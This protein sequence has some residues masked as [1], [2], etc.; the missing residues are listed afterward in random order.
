MPGKTAMHN[1]NQEL[2]RRFVLKAD[3]NGC[4]GLP[5][6]ESLVKVVALDGKGGI[7]FGVETVRRE[8]VL[9]FAVDE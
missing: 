4:F 2:L 1:D 7:A 6:N 9:R 3:A 5:V 8:G